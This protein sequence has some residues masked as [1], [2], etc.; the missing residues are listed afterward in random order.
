MKPLLILLL[1]PILQLCQEISL[2]TYQASN[3]VQSMVTVLEQSTTIK[4]SQRDLKEI[5]INYPNAWEMVDN[6][7]PKTKGIVYNLVKR[8]IA[9]EVTINQ[10]QAGDVVQFWEQG[11]GHCGIAKGCNYP[12]HLLWLWSSMPN[13]NFALTSF[14]FPKKFYAC[15]IKKQFLTNSR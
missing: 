13:T 5:H 8:G 7:N 11:W 3:C 4:F 15:R 14:T 10:L 12:K 9:T 6:N 2:P 1:H